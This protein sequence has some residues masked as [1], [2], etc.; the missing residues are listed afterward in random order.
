MVQFNVSLHWFVRSELLY[1][2]SEFPKE[3]AI[4]FKDIIDLSGDRDER[5]LVEYMQ[6][7]NTVKQSD[8]SIDHILNRAGKKLQ[9]DNNKISSNFY[10]N[11]S[12]FNGVDESGFSNCAPMFSWLHYTRYRPPKLPSES[13]NWMC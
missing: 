11:C 4:M 2:R 1:F 13:N 3:S 6:D 9:C 8:F 12:E 5:R 7:N 10:R